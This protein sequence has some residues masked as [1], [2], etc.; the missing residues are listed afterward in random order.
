V[1]QICQALKPDPANPAAGNKSLKVLDLSYNPITGSSIFFLSDMLDVNRNLEYL[2]LSK[3]NLQAMQ[4]AKIFD[5]IGRLPFPQDQVEPHQA[6]IKARDAV[7]E[8]NKKLKA[9]KKPEEPVPL[10]DMIENTTYTNSEGQEVQ[11]Y[12]LLKNV[13]FKHINLCA[14]DINDECKDSIIQLMRRTNDDFGITL[15][16]NPINK[17]VIDAFNKTVN[18]VHATRAPADGVDANISVRRITF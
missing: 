7:I 15:A 1:K 9:S 18:E 12:V 17:N 10:L 3:C 13:Q 6:K 11:G 16:G 2:G 4:A 5:Q 8:K 14:N